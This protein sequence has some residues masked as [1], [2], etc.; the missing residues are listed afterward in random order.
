MAV[1][2]GISIL[3]L[4][5]QT[6]GVA[7]QIPDGIVERIGVLTILDHRSTTSDDYF[8]HEGTL[9]A[10]ADVFDLDTQNWALR[11]P[12]LT[13]GLPFRLAIERPAAPP[14]GEQEGAPTLW[15]IDIQVWDVEI[16]IPGAVPAQPVGGTGV[17]PLTLKKTGAGNVYLVARG[18]VRISGGGGGDTQ[19]QVVD[20]PDPLDPTAPTG[21]V[22]RLTA[23]PP[24][25]VFGDTNFGMTLDQFVLDLSSTFT[26]AE[27]AARGHGE[28]W[29]GL[30]F[31]ETTFYFPPETP[32][33]NNLSVSA[34]D[35]II[36]DPGGLQGEIRVE[37]GHD[38]NDVYKTRLT[39]KEQLSDGSEVDVPETTVGGGPPLEYA[40][41]LGLG[42]VKRRV[43]AVFEIGAG[44][45]I[46]GHTDLAVVGV[47]WKLPDGSE[48]NSSTTPWFDA[49]TS[50]LKYSLRVGAPGTAG[51]VAEPPSNVPPGQTPLVEVTVTFPLQAGGPT[52]IGPIV[53]ATIDGDTLR[54]VLHLRGPRD[55]L[56]TVTLTSRVGTATWTL[57][58]GSAPSSWTW[59]SSI[60]LPLLPDI[61]S[62]DLVVT[63]EDG[64]RR[65]RI[66]VV[67]TGP[68]AVGHQNTDVNTSPS[69]VTVVGTGAATPTSVINTFLAKPFHERADQSAAPALATIAGTDVTVP[70]GTDA[71][72]EVPVPTGANDPPPP[73]AVPNSTPRVVQVQYDWDQ[74]A[75]IRVLY[76]YSGSPTG[77]ANL[78][79]ADAYPLA[80]GFTGRSGPNGNNVQ[81]QLT[82]WLAE[83][84]A[85]NGRKYYVLGRTDDLKLLG[86]KAENDT[87]NNSLATLR[88]NA[89]RDALIAAGATP[90]DITVAIESSG[91]GSPPAGSPPARFS[92]A[93]RLALPWPQSPAF[94]ATEAP[95]WN[96]KWNRDRVDDRSA[97]I[98]DPNR[99]PYRCAEIYVVDTTAPSEPPTVPPSPGV[100]TRILV[101]GPDG[102]PPPGVSSTTAGPP[103]TDYRVRLRVKWDSPTYVGPAD[104]IPTEAEALFAWKAAEI[105][106]PSGGGP[107][108]PPTGPDYW[109]ILLHW[110]YDA[111]SG[112]TEASGALSLPDG[113]LTWQS[114][115][116]AGALAF[117]PVLASLVDAADVVPDSMQFVA[118]LA[119]IAVGAAIGEL[120]NS[121]GTPSSVD[122]DKFAISYKW[123]GAPHVAATVDYTIDL[124]VNVNVLGNTLEGHLRLRYKGVGLRF[125][126]Q[127]G[128]GLD[129]VALTYDDMSV[130][131]V[132]TG[133]WTL[134][135]P[136]G[137]LIRIAASR[138][139]SGSQW[140]EFDLEFALDLG[141]V[142]LE[143]ATIRLKLPD[144]SAPFS[145]E[146]RGLTA[147]VDIPGA[148]KGRGAVTIGDGGSFRAL[149]SLEVIP[150]KLSAYG[151]LAVDQDF[152]AVEV[153]VQLPVG[154][155]L[156]A[157]GFGI[158]GFIGRFVANGTRNLDG[159]VATE[160]VQKQLEW[161]TRSPDLKYK[162]KSGQYA[163]GVGAVVGTLPDSGFTFNAEGSLTIGFPD[164]S[165]IFG[166][167]AHLVT[168][169]KSAATESGTPSGG[170]GLRIL[171]M[172]LIEPTSIM[173][174]VRGSYE[175]PKVLKLEIPISA[176]FPL[177]GGDAWYIRIG[178]DNHA[179]RPGSPVT[180]TLLPEILDVR[181]WAFVMIEERQL[182]GLGGTL[183]PLDLAD[184]LDFDGFSIGM[185][186]GFDLKWSAGPF[187]L[188]ISA[189][190]L[191]GIGTKPLLF[192]G[193]AGVKGELDLVLISVGVDGLVHFHISPG[194]SY[195]EGH[196]CGHVDLFFFEI[197][198]CVDIRI[199]DDP[200]SNIPVPESPIAGMDLCDHLAVVKGTAS[201]NGAGAVPT[202][203]PDTIAVLRFAHFIADGLGASDFDRRLVPPA[204]LS[205]WSGSTE[206]KYAFRLKTVEL[207]KL[208]GA[209]PNNAAHWTKV[210]GPFDSAWWLP[211]WRASII[212]GGDTTG[213]STEEGRELGLFSWD[214]R[215]WSRWLG[216]GS[217]EVPGNPGNTVEHVCDEVAPAE[218]SCAYGRAREYAYGTLGQ[219]RAQ[220]PAS[221]VFPSRFKA[222]ARFPTGLDAG[223]LAALGADVG[224]TWIPGAV[225]PLHGAIDLH[226]TS[227]AEGWRFPSWRAVGKIVGT[228]PIVLPLSKPLLA[229]ELVLEVCSDKETEVIGNGICDDMPSG[230]GMIDGFTGKSKTKYSG[231]SLQPFFTNNE[232]ALRLLKN[233]L[234]GQYPAQ[235]DAVAVEVD[236][237]GASATLTAFGPNNV[238][239]GTAQTVGTGRQWLRVEAPGIVRMRLTGEK[240]PVVYEVCWG[241]R[242]PILDLVTFEQLEWPRVIAFDI[243][244][245]SKQLQPEVLKGE[246]TCPK[247]LYKLPE[248]EGWTR[249]EVAPW[250]RGD[251][252]LVALCGVTLEARAAQQAEVEHRASLIDLMQQWVAA[253]LDNKPTHTTYLD[254]VS[255]YEIRVAWQYQGFRP[256][257]PGDEPAPPAS[258]GWI[259]PPGMPERFR[260]TTAAFGLTAAPPPVEGSSLED[261]AQGGPGFDERTF[262]PRGVARYLTRAAP[263]HEDP[264]HFLDDHA[265]FWFMVDHLESLVDKYDRTLQVKVLHTRP[266]AGSMHGVEAH[267]PGGLHLLDVTIA[268]EWKVDTRTW[269]AADQLLVEAVAAAPCIGG[270]PAVGSSSVSVTADLEP[271]TEYDLLLN[272][273]PK[274]V[275]AFA[276]VP[277]ARSHFRTSR[278][279]NPTEMLRALG[280]ASPL[281]LSPPTD[282]LIAAPLAAGPLAI[283][284]TELDAALTTLGLDP[285]PLPP[286][287]RTTVLW[288]Q[289]TAPGQPWRVAGVLVEADE[290]V[291]RAGLRTGAQGEPEPPPRLEVMSLR[292]FR[293]YEQLVTFPLPPHFV[294]TRTALASL[295]ERVR[296]ASGTRSIFIANTPIPM[297][298]GRIY[299]L[300]VRFK[301][302]GNPGATG[303]A[304]M[305]D[306]PL[307]VLEEGD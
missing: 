230:D 288:L 99:R 20:S 151:A 226:G 30:A 214:P 143:G 1:R 285:W 228:A 156:G 153:G 46:P 182:H 146:F 280:F 227:L 130:E 296:N 248:G 29:Q 66:D 247:L 196:F 116:L 42:G 105:E 137:N 178:S 207:W 170:G 286:A 274:I 239:L 179:T 168:Q 69:R 77:D 82:S 157:T 73:P 7:L 306:R 25:F 281:G 171:G 301:E 245:K 208:T 8:L 243:H 132:S 249:V 184:P 244:D 63:N 88:A 259:D 113:A 51:L 78:H 279:R 172:I 85:P 147:T 70:Q 44:E 266:P 298:G 41:T 16:L 91:F 191:V 183:V 209:D 112:Q 81:Q 95:V 173:I 128:G 180:I 97:A 134:G 294:T 273:A 21:A 24:S 103:P 210:T 261:P 187:K 267:H 194:Y 13:H 131:V 139:G 265:G 71:E 212:E 123:N 193:A 140:M 269:F 262:D 240:Q 218:P 75:P 49:P 275:D 55:R 229:G 14:A 111:R 76:P 292:I 297:T 33:L 295:S 169:R 237:A 126:G 290:P 45:L 252:A 2:R 223:M 36:G 219:F 60:T 204:A 26:P 257:N 114:N 234:D 138:M 260:F 59:T 12:G 18:V 68:I 246:G 93:R 64:T 17:T 189:F 57:T 23:R 43:R 167:D 150:A 92:G 94:G 67:P 6:T 145:V 224:W 165:V 188:E 118:A 185:G 87:Y 120:L 255:T 133:A 217:Q 72:V 127:P 272:A 236:P 58:G 35:V 253:A 242:R 19:V 38:F 100:P 216:E 181:A 235:T 89:A 175:I 158:F 115:P 22:I 98:N 190:L 80:L 56:A 15:T 37:F 232:W 278:Y 300:E 65:V 282:A 119:M 221:A 176:Y 192:A 195:F 254:D 268:A 107:I 39:I 148:L 238:V 200:P 303:A 141:V 142:R 48:G 155:P 47:W 52:G 124:R 28:E 10:L 225:A 125:D 277:I 197:S 251:V 203:W 9:Q 205:P 222:F 241:R 149:L 293:T 186:A 117:G 199:G 144:D 108:P 304:P 250:N 231:S 31:R 202:V 305:V 284:D 90:A 161:Y 32:L 83:L 74:A 106:L 154:I 174:G 104:A 84:G 159:L 40:M 201:R 162:R 152:V 263:S 4:L 160:P 276:E 27:I 258:N 177:A 211:S 136:L 102:P 215:A 110:V 135:G 163:F 53:D 271:R 61:G 198:G 289:P 96:R 11:I 220:P 256:A 79:E 129:G 206:L 287:P 101:P 291:W 122:I 54:N 299:D 166:I 34:R 213:P 270:T 121:G 307:F 5:P 62:R 3:D 50:E 109:E 264:P 302:N 283:G 233:V 86:N 164:V